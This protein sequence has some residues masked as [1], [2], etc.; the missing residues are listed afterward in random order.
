MKRELLEAICKALVENR[1][2]LQRATAAA[3]DAAT[4]EESAP[5]NKYDTR[6]LEASYLAGAQS[7]RLAELERDIDALKRFQPQAFDRDDPI[8]LG[9]LVELDNGTEQ[10][11]VFLAPFAGGLRVVF[12]GGEVSVITPQSPLALRLLGATVGDELALS[13]GG[14]SLAYE[15][16][17]VR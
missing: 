2:V 10:R 3:H 7:K 12:R 13:V 16:L 17:S 15:V 14:R 8:A 5:E 6:G 4:N 11:V 9:A 1:V